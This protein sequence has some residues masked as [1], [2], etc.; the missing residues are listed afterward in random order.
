MGTKSYGPHSV[1]VPE[2]ERIMTDQIVNQDGS[3]NVKVAGSNVEAAGGAAPPSKNVVIGGVTGAN[4]VYAAN[5]DNA[6]YRNLLVGLRSSTGLEPLITASQDG[7]NHANPG[8]LTKS[9]MMGTTDGAVTAVI[10]VANVTKYASP[11]MAGPTAFWTPAAGKKARLQGFIFA[12]DTTGQYTIDDNG[13]TVISLRVLA[14]TV[15]SVLLP[16]NGYI[17]STINNPLRLS[18]PGASVCNITAFGNE[19]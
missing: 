15:V 11:A 10:R 19:E 13:T 16:L 17:S 12:A 4:V 9:V 6:S 8:L 18:G 5:I 2:T 7:I 1:S 14:N 3:A